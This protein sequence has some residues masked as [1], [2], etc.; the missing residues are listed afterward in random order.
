GWYNP[1]GAPFFGET[2]ISETP[3]GQQ[4]QSASVDAAAAPPRPSTAPCDPRDLLGEQA[5]RAFW[6]DL[7]QLL[8]ERYRQWVA[9][10]GDRQLGFA[11]TKYEL[12][13]ECERQGFAR[14]E[15]L[16]RSIE[17]EMSDLVIDSPIPGEN[18]LLS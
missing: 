17:P 18:S 1:E 11:R 12:C 16:I 9:Y 8:Q 4:P 2:M 7:P 10:H 3:D 6:R 13:Q 5:L 14:D 15:V